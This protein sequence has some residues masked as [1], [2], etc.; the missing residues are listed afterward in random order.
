M[1]GGINLFLAI[2][3]TPDHTFEHVRMVVEVI[4]NSRLTERRSLD[5]PIRQHE[6]HCHGPSGY[7]DDGE[8]PHFP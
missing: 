3:Q 4:G 1:N 5:V 7:N 8:Q 6:R 2:G